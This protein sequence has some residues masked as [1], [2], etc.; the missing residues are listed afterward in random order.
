MSSNHAHLFP[1]RLP[2]A[3]ALSCCARQLPAFLG[4]LHCQRHQQLAAT[5]E[6]K[7]VGLFREFLTYYFAADESN[8]GFSPNETSK[9]LRAF[10]SYRPSFPLTLCW[11]A[12]EAAIRAS[13]FF[14][15]RW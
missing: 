7:L 8:V 3:D 4:F 9:V 11:S 13:P 5:G 14:D 6:W 2:L 15:S 1:V 12:F 10:R